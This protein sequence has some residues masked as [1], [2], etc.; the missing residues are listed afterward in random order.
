MTPA[1]DQGVTVVLPVL[2]EEATVGAALESLENQSVGADTLEVL[3]YDGGSSDRTAEVARSFE[4]AAPWRRFEVNHNSHRTVP[5]AL[6]AAL[7]SSRCTW[8]TRLDGRTAFSENYIE[9]CVQA[10][11]SGD[12]ITA[13]GGRLVAVAEGKV[14]NSIAAAVTHSLGVGS[15]FRTESEVSDLP[16]HPFAIWRLADVRSLGGFDTNLVRNQDDE[17]S[18]RATSRG[19]RIRLVPDA[20]VTYRPRARLRGLAAQYFQYGLWK[21]AVG[22][23]HR[24][25]PLRSAAPTAVTAGAA[26]AATRAT[27]GSPLPF[28]ACA[29]AY[30]WAGRR[31]AATR[32]DAGAIPSGAALAAIHVSYGAGVAVGAILPS[33][34]RTP[35][36]AG[37]VR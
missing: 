37:R 6:N 20:F 18:M 33:I 29:M 27:R 28:V 11:S 24:R 31:V 13:A 7:R 30:A 5:H 21:S 3:V 22:R 17:F 19:A 23:R 8:F 1:Y 36:G 26:W 4:F 35:L 15:G 14:A 34:T 10:A 2:D 9:A 12:G 25:F 32:T 16:H